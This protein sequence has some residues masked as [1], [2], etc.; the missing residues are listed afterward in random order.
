MLDLVGEPNDAKLEDIL[1]LKFTSLKENV[2]YK[3][4]SFAASINLGVKIYELVQRKL[5]R[6]NE[7]V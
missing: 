6:Q 2:S 3:L 1:I 5:R 7:E 4:K